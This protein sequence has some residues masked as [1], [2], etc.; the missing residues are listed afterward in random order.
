M[1]G[2]KLDLEQLPK[3]LVGFLAGSNLFT[4]SSL[5]VCFFGEWPDMS[6]EPSSCIRISDVLG[7]FV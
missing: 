6:F 3:S 5:Q 7:L 2:S 1:L 4:D